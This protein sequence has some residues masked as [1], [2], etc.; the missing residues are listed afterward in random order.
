MSGGESMFAIMAASVIG[1]PPEVDRIRKVAAFI[2]V[3]IGGI[4]SLAI[5]PA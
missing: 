5:G 3:A 4:E 2:V 1:L